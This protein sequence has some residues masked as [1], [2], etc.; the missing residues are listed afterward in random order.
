MAYL[1]GKALSEYSE[2]KYSELSKEDL[3][4]AATGKQT[5]YFTVYVPIG[6]KSPQ[7]A[8]EDIKEFVQMFKQSQEDLRNG[9]YI[10]KYFFM[11]TT[12][13]GRIE[14]MNPPTIIHQNE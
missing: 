5:L 9:Q 6:S 4:H 2:H 11:P 3:S 13:E 14:L 12:G 10:E 1:S 7:K 8:K